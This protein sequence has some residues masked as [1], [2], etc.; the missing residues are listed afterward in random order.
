MPNSYSS[1]PSQ[2]TP[3]NKTA[4]VLTGLIVFIIAFQLLVTINPPFIQQDKKDGTCKCAPNN[5]KTFFIA[6]IPVA[7]A[8]GILALY[9]KV[10][11]S[12]K[13]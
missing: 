12:K 2:K 4:L 6:L 5:G 1:F 9:Q 3:L 13:K 7:A 8:V 11:S 10:S